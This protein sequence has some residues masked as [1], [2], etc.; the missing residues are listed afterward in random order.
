[1]AFF[2]PSFAPYNFPAIRAF[3]HHDVL[4]SGVLLVNQQKLATPR[5][6]LFNQMSHHPLL[7]LSID[8][9]QALPTTIPAIIPIESAAI[10]APKNGVQIL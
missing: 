4:G 7:N 8:H 9:K 10:E 5:A 6:L 2:L 1:L 3:I